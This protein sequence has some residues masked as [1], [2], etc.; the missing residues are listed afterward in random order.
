[1]SDPPSTSCTESYPQTRPRLISSRLRLAHDPC[2]ALHH[3]VGPRATPVRLRS[4]WSRLST[5]PRVAP[6]PPWSFL[7][8]MGESVCSKRARTIGTTTCQAPKGMGSMG[9]TDDAP[10]RGPSGRKLPLSPPSLIAAA[11]ADATGAPAR[12]PGPWVLHDRVAVLQPRARARPEEHRRVDPGADGEQPVADA[13]HGVADSSDRQCD[14]PLSV[15][16]DAD[17]LQPRPVSRLFPDVLELQ[18]APPLKRVWAGV[19]DPQ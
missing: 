2:G 12:P 10:M 16:R 11:T 6:A 9:A 19:V 17:L 14:V 13:G 18:Y 3:V 7:W 1:M 15:H 5:R 4:L 8:H